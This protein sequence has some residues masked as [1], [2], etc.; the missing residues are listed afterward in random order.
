MP[1]RQKKVPKFKNEQ[2]EGVFWQKHD[3]APFLDWSKA[4]NT[5]FPDLQPSTKTISLRLP[6]NL[7]YSLK[8]EAHKHD[9]PYQS[10][11]KIILDH[12]LHYTKKELIK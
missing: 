2:A 12:G 9:V 3:S 10:L 6:E 5:T 7:L 11:I 8:V 4:K 1:K